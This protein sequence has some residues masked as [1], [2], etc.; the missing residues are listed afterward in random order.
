MLILISKKLSSQMMSN[1]PK[2]T[3]TVIM[4]A[5]FEPLAFLL[6][7]SPSSIY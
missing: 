7:A 4:K 6:K 5:D 2:I 3:G 1:L